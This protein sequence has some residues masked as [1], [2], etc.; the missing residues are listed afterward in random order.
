MFK[1]AYWTTIVKPTPEGTEVTIQ[2]DLTLRP[3]YIFLFP[4]LL[5]TSKGAFFRDLQYLKRAL[6]KE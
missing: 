5:L 3:L 2:V 4:V 1:V 6:E